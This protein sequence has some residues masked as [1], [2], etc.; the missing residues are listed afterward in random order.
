MG[1]PSRYD[2][3]DYAE[4]YDQ[5]RFGGGFGKVLERQEIDLF[6]ELL[7]GC[8]GALL[9]AGSGT[10][11]LSLA[12]LDRGWKV[13]S[14]DLSLEMLRVARLKAGALKPLASICDMQALAFK[15]RAF[16]CAISSRALMHV[17]DWRAAVGELCRVSSRAVVFDF[18]PR[19]SSSGLDALRLRLPSLRPGKRKYRYRTYLL[20][21]IAGEL[22]KQGFTVVEARRTFLLPVLLHRWLD[23]PGLSARI[24]RFCAGLGLVRWFGAPVTVKAVRKTA[25]PAT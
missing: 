2:Q 7:E 14:T 15:D 19:Y 21:E 10:G 13:T 18:P 17:K 25:G 11:K 23:R 20:R 22:E 5:D 4:E 6:V 12:L 9:D 16:C 3:R 1:Q 8:E 24:E